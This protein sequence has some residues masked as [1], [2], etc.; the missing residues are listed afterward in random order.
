MKA[1]FIVFSLGVLALL[2]GLANPPRSTLGKVIGAIF[3]LVMVI[4]AVDLY[5]SNN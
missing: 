1:F 5:L 4:A 3:L 2:F